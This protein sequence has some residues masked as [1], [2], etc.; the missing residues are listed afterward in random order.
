LHFALLYRFDTPLHRSAAIPY[1]ARTRN[2]I[3][4]IPDAAEFL[5]TEEQR[6]GKQIEFL[7]PEA[8]HVIVSV[9][10]KAGAESANAR[11]ARLVE[12]LRQ[13]QFEVAVRTNLDEIATEANGL[14]SAGQLRALVA[15]G[16]D[17]TAAELVNRTLPG[18]PLTILPAGNENLVAR[19]LGLGPTPDE[20][21]RTVVEGA[22]VRCDAGLAGGRIF[23]VM[24]SCGFD[25]EVVR[26]VHEHRTGHVTTASYFTPIMS[27]IRYYD[28]PELRVYWNGDGAAHPGEAP[29]EAGRPVETYI[30]VR[31]LFAFNFPCYGG[32]LHIA[33]EA[34]E[35]DGLLDICTFRHGGLWAG[36]YYTAAVFAGTQRWLTDFAERQV[37]RLRVTSDAQVPYQLDGDPGGFLPVEIEV[38]PGRL[39]LIVPKERQI[40]S[41]GRLTGS[42]AG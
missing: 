18:V 14:F 25:A 16:G 39:T 7:S 29:E 31:W 36:L 42:Q 21:C 38:L 6:L 8:R 33:P 41:T 12:L 19:H 27:S 26:G 35:T 22:V 20:C 23:V 9:N 17:G 5:H 24:L 37:A 3:Y 4:R 32:G 1:N 10:P 15:V 30:G 34:D 13:Q 40:S 2:D 11:V 28:F